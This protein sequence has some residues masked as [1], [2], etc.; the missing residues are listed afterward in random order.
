M[1]EAAKEVTPHDLTPFDHRTDGWADGVRIDR[2][3]GAISPF[4]RVRAYGCVSKDEGG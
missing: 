1:T 2:Q 3:S 4:R